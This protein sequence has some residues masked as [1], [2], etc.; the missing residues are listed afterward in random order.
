[1]AVR[2]RFTG[3][4]QGALLG[5]P[6]TGRQV[7]VAQAAVHRVVDGKI[8]DNWVVFDALGLMQQLGVVPAPGQ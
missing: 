4:H 8:T 7:N 5:I 3:T 1:V 6:A 2:T